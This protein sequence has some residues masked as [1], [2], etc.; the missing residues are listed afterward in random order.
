MRKTGYHCCQK[1]TGILIYKGVW[2]VIDFFPLPYIL[3]QWIELE[4]VG[5]VKQNGQS[6][7]MTHVYQS[8]LLSI[9]EVK[10]PLAYYILLKGVRVQALLEVVFLL[11]VQ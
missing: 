6:G 2:I 7:L 1:L 4:A 10:M 8:V 11:I 3:N 9:E 5:L